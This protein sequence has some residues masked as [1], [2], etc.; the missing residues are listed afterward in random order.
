MGGS[1]VP[2]LQLRGMR[3]LREAVR[4][5]AAVED[6]EVPDQALL[7][8]YQ[9]VIVSALTAVAPASASTNAGGGGAGG[10]SA[11]GGGGAPS[12]ALQSA[13]AGLAVD[14]LVGGLSR[15]GGSTRRLLPLLLPV[16]HRLPY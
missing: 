7:E 14:L 1:P 11:S 4:A 8:Q 13:A 12:P 16:C 5:F 6:P 15:D 9:V 10:A 3:L 2:P